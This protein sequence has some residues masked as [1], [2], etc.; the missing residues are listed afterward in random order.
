MTSFCFRPAVGKDYDFETS[1]Y[2]Y[3][4]E[5]TATGRCD[6]DCD[7]N[8][9]VTISMHFPEDD[10]TKYYYGHLGPDGNLT[11]TM[12]WDDDSSGHPSKFIFTRLPAEVM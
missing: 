2:C 7:G 10:F 3:G 11:G 9:S 12:G 4:D 1:G 8:I 5:F 6:Q